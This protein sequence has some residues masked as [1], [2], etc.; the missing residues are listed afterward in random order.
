MNIKI[1]IKITSKTK[2]KDK[3]KDKHAASMGNVILSE[4]AERG[5]GIK[6]KMDMLYQKQLNLKNGKI[7][8][9]KKLLEE[10]VPSD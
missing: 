7:E 9:L 1:T 2:R 3:D 6:I 5:N 10:K 4:F 8:I